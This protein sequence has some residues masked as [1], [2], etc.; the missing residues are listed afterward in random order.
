MKYG[1]HE[2][3]LTSADVVA[4]C[5]AAKRLVA[6]AKAEEARGQFT[7]VDALVLALAQLINDM[8]GDVEH[9]C[10]M[11]EK[12]AASLIDNTN[13]L[14]RMYAMTARWDDVDGDDFDL[15]DDDTPSIPPVLQ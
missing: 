12:V 14:A 10:A 3:A 13:G 6:L 4:T 11:V 8:S 1:E 7:G 15:E 2:D 5:S 9:A